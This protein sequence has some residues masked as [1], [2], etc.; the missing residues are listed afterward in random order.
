MLKHFV[1]LA[2]M[3]L[4]MSSAHDIRDFGAIANDDSLLT[5]QENARAFMET[6]VVANITDYD[7]TVVVPANFTFHTMPIWAYNITNI[8]F[9]ID[10]TV[11]LSKA[12]H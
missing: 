7:R 12:H 1:T 10:G 11:K 3:L 2:S 8:T 4:C 9:I 6:I 5:E